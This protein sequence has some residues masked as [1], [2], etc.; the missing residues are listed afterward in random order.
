MRVKL[1][2]ITTCLLLLR[3]FFYAEIKTE[4]WI[5][6]PVFG[7]VINDILVESSNSNMAYITKSKELFK[8]INGGLSWER[9]S[10]PPLN[11]YEEENIILAEDPFSIET[12]YAGIKNGLFK[13]IDGGKNWTDLSAG[14]LKNVSF[15]K[16]IDSMKIYV[17][18]GG[19]LYKTINGGK[20]WGDIT[21]QFEIGFI[22]IDRRTE[23]IYTVSKSDLVIFYSDNG[24]LTWQEKLFLAKVLEENGKYYD[25][26]NWLELRIHPLNSKLLL[27]RCQVIGR[28][29]H[30]VKSSDSGNT[31]EEIAPTKNN[32]KLLPYKDSN[33]GFLEGGFNMFFDIND[34]NIFYLTGAQLWGGGEGVPN[35]FLKTTD[36]G[37]T[38]EFLQIDKINM[39]VYKISSAPTPL[40]LYAA[41]PQGVYKTADG[42][43]NWRPLNIGLPLGKRSDILG[44]AKHYWLSL[45]PEN[46]VIYHIIQWPKHYNT[47]IVTY[48]TEDGGLT[49]QNYYREERS[50]TWELNQYGSYPRH[51]QPLITFEQ[52]EYI[53]GSVGSGILKVK[54]PNSPEWKTI[55]TNVSSPLLFNISKSNPKN[56]YLIAEEVLYVSEDEGF[57]WTAIK[58]P[59]NMRKVDIADMKV[60]GSSQIIY[61]LG[62]VMDAREG[63]QG[64]QIYK[65]EDG[66]K[67]WI[68]IS[69]QE[70]KEF[71]Y[72]TKNFKVT[73]LWKYVTTFAMDYA[74]PN[75]VFLGTNGHGIYKTTNGG[76]IWEFTSKDFE[77][78]GVE[79]KDILIN[80]ITIDSKN[81][82]IVYAGTNVGVFRSMD[83]GITWKPFN[84]GLSDR[85]IETIRVNNST[86]QLI[87]LKTRNGDVWRLMDSSALESIKKRWETLWEK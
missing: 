4:Q 15:I 19:K 40:M 51:A 43:K 10:I 67:D 11:T 49:W 18:S 33:V 41:T 25:C 82:N 30:L 55:K 17:L 56:L 58:F 77:E 44:E 65:S 73:Y 53:L 47:E 14:V 87:V 9:G 69:P 59:M 42:G 29:W 46:Y 23:T 85:D 7:P 71:D 34:E 60:N 83:K 72:K 52:K 35:G 76:K 84:N 68:N 66:G 16:V 26:K 75:T 81:P 86:P 32:V 38:Y 63:T 37:H 22:E 12:I 54:E 21:P 74:S 39:E 2:F 70:V 1:I 45:D 24:G 36:G 57:S 50:G 31:W 78:N 62:Y 13:S 79:L 28:G 27:G 3:T 6:I 48:K 20:S 64:N 80:C 5:S 61:L 8:T